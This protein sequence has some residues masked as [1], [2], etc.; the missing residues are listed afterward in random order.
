MSFLKRHNKSICQIKVIDKK[1]ALGQ[2][3]RLNAIILLLLI[4]L[5]QFY[6]IYSQKKQCGINIQDSFEYYA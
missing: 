5:L 3:K 1:L 4:F 6:G 2:S